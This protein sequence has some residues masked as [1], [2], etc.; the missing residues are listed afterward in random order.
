MI[1][2]ADA[3]GMTLD[4][5]KKQGISS[6]SIGSS[7]FEE[8]SEELKRKR[9]L[10][11]ELMEAVSDFKIKEWICSEMHLYQLVDDLCRHVLA[12]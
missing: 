1:D 5:L 3:A 12:S 4:T 2:G 7:K 9:G 11:D 8:G 10:G 6:F